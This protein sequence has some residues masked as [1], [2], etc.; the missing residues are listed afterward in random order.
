MGINTTEF[1]IQG[2]TRKEVYRARDDR[3]K[4]GWRCRKRQ[5]LKTGIK[6]PVH[7]DEQSWKRG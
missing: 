7:E 3:N 1:N 4:E 2:H 5:T 6:D